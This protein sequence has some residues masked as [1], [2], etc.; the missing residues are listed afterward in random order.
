VARH[1]RT[2]LFVSHN[3]AAVRAL[4]RRAIVMYAG[5]VAFDGAVEQAIAHYLASNEASGEGQVTFGAEGLAFEG[6]RIRDVRLVDDAGVARAMFDSTEPIRVEIDYDVLGDLR[7]ARTV[8]AISTQEGEVAFQ[9]TDHLDRSDEQPPG[10]YR[11]SC[12]IPGGLLNR[13]T[14]VVEMGFDIPGVRLIAPRRL[15]LSFT[16]S[17]A[18]NHGSTFP[19]PWPGVLSPNLQWTLERL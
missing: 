6:L 9:S 18:G 13:R 17:G 11:T 12:T 2:V 7:G 10:R 8:L 3:M 1:G 16:V 19:E 5:R 14:Y 4:C 15:Y